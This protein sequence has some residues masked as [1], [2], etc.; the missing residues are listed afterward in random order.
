MTYKTPLRFTILQFAQ[1]FLIDAVTFI[2]YVA[3]S[4]ISTLPTT[5]SPLKNPQSYYYTLKSMRIK[6]TLLQFS[7]NQRLSI[8][9]SD[10]ML[11]VGGQRPIR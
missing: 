3:P 8:H 5:F 6:G 9:H 4:R 10:G 7:Q 2:F 11:K 1:R